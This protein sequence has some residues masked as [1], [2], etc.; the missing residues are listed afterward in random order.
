MNIQAGLKKE[1][2][3]VELLESIKFSHT[4]FAL[5]F[6]LLALVLARR[7]GLP[8]L[9]ELIL[10]VTCMVGA[11]TWAMGVNRLADARID[12][13]NPRT[14][15]RAVPAGRLSSSAMAFFTAA[16]A[17]VFLGGSAA[18]SG[19]ALACAVPVLLIL[20]SYSW[21]KRLTFLCHFYLGFCLG[22]APVGAWV[23]LRGEF[24]WPLLTLT[25]AITFW[26][27]GFD[28]LYALQDEH[29]DREAGL[30]SIPA[31]FGTGPALVVA[32]VSH[33]ISALLFLGF[34]FLF[35]LG[36][37]YFAGL[38]LAAGLMLWQHRLTRGGD[39]SRIGLA[40]FNLNGWIAVL[41][42][43][44]ASLSILAGF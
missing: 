26:V 20:A 39:L 30:H 36:I 18:L 24:P 14:T 27:A 3:V 22:L 31:R 34:G 10:I 4:V 33:S 35:E 32:R 40:F 13:A 19:V 11:R 42:F 23:A 21:A 41:L 7:G 15:T 17:L 43:L 37:A 9:R 2:V 38:A 16:G 6:A 29:F 28:I 8:S 1:N 5:P 12:A 44:S 25:F